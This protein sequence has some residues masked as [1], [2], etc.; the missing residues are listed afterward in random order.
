[1]ADNNN[2]QNVPAAFRVPVAVATLPVTPPV[3]A[4][5]VVREAPAQAQ[6]EVTDEP[7]FTV[8]PLPKRMQDVAARKPGPVEGMTTIVPSVTVNT[9]RIADTWFHFEAG[10]AQDVPTGMIPTLVQQR[11]IPPRY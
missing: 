2:R 9:M 3:P 1:M 11:I 4:A 5:E 7:P 6:V 8:S 10:K